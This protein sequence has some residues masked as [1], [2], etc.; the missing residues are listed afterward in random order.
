MPAPVPYVHFSGAAADALRFYQS[1]FGGDL[2]LHSFGDF[3]RDDGHPDLI[4]HGELRGTVDLFGA[5]VARGETAVPVAG[6][7]FALLGEGDEATSRRWFD[8]L[9]ADGTVIDPLQRR[10]WGDYDGQ[11]RDRYGVT[12]LIGFAPASRP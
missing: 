1:V 5:D 9:V 12:W 8:A 11:V 2:Q 10:G 7:M 6:V 3:G 4:A